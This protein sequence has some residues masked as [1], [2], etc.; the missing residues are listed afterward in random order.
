MPRTR[1][2][3]VDAACHG[4]HAAVLWALVS[5]PGSIACPAA[6]AGQ[7]ARTPPGSLEAKA[8]QGGWTGPLGVVAPS[9]HP[10]KDFPRLSPGG[11][12]G[13]QALLHAAHGLGAPAPS[14]W[15]H[16]TPPH[17]PP[18][19]PLLSGPLQASGPALHQM[20]MLHRQSWG[21]WPLSGGSR[22]SGSMLAPSP[23][24]FRPLPPGPS[25]GPGQA[26][27]LPSSARPPPHGG[28]LKD[29]GQAG[30]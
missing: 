11:G 17:S 2:G 30:P 3:G 15:S 26:L 28:F 12:L 22:A 21:A 6:G 9:G 25:L 14:L 23:P 4:P 18:L 19:S 13:L 20:L 7:P 27:L 16:T 8:G 24:R 29:R 1:V 5:R 10:S